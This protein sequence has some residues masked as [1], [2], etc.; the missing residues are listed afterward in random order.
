M[1]EEIK[2]TENTLTKKDRVSMFLRSNFQQASF[3]FE[4]IHALGF[5][6]D[7]VPASRDFITQKRNSQKR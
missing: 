2:N 7:M 4:R 5:A 6:F 1:S 3:N